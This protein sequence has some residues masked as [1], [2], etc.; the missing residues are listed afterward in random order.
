MSNQFCIDIS[1]WTKKVEQNLDRFMLEF[2]QDLAEEVIVNTPVDT[3]F[4]RASW[5]AN[6]GSPDTKT[7]GSETGGS[8]SASISQ[9]LS[10]VS[11]KLIGVKGGDTV[12]F[13]NNAEYGA[14]VEFGTQFQAGQGFVR[15]AVN[16]SATLARNAAKR[17]S[18]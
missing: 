8:E 12:Y 3:G 11:A 18:K 13:T 7:V 14:Y 16:K 1:R 2:S 9:S 10:R 4:L 5:T 15:N 17:I 6:I